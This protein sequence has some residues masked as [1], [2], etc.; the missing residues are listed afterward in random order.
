MRSLNIKKRKKKE[1]PCYHTG[2]N[3]RRVDE[4]VLDKVQSQLIKDLR[5]LHNFKEVSGKNVEDPLNFPH[6]WVTT[7]IQKGQGSKG[8]MKMLGEANEALGPISI[9]KDDHHSC[10]GLI[11]RVPVVL[12]SSLYRAV[13]LTFLRDIGGLAHDGAITNEMATGSMSQTV[14]VLTPAMFSPGTQPLYMFMMDLRLAS[15][16]GR[17]QRSDSRRSH[18]LL[19]LQCR[20]IDICCLQ[21]TRFDSNFHESIL[22]RDYLSF[23]AYFDGRSRGVT[24][25]ISRRLDAT[26]ALVLLDLAGRLCVLDVTIKDKAF[27]L[28]GVYGHNA[29]SELPAFFRRIQLYVVPSKQVILVGDWNAFLDPNLDRGAISAGTNT[30]DARYFRDFVQ[31]F[32]LIDKFR[33]RHPN[34]IAWT[35]TGR[36]VALYGWPEQT[37]PLSV[38]ARNQT[39]DFF[40]PEISPYPEVVRGRE[41]ELT[42][43]PRRE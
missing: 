4:G 13:K 23:S 36:G 35:W 37:I 33:E 22:S 15:L 16:N 32:D 27:Q 7:V 28:I 10:K 1:K 31:Q 43:G 12:H 9:I 38:S 40:G 34:K 26:C 11:G 2:H 42:T 41:R 14:N 20:G 29:T 6:T 21:E 30:L 24:W 8:A 17:G 39:K 3:I 25:L 18:L 5:V 19:Y